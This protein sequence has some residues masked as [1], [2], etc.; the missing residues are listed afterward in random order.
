MV[1]GGPRINKGRWTARPPRP[2]EGPAW[3]TKRAA[4]ASGRGC[5]AVTTAPRAS[6][7]AFRGE[8]TRAA[9]RLPRAA[10]QSQG[11]CCCD[12]RET[13]RRRCCAQM[14]ARSPRCSQAGSLV[15]PAARHRRPVRFG[16]RARRADACAEGV[17]RPFPLGGLDALTLFLPPL[18]IDAR[19]RLDRLQTPGVAKYFRF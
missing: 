18:P 1:P 11:R 19:V 14:R 8:S 12:A 13:G 10:A 4:P 16:R 15:I 3:P 2:T 9:F 6:G 7:R 5:P 17:A